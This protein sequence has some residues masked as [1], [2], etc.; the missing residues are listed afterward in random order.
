MVP[1]DAVSD[2][3]APEGTL[4]YT[5]LFQGGSEAAVAPVYASGMNKLPLLTVFAALVPCTPLTAQSRPA[6]LDTI[7]VSSR[8]RTADPA[9]V[10]SVISRDDIARS[11]ARNVAE[12]LSVQMGVDVYGRSAA[13]AD[14]S[15]RGS[16]ADQTL[17]LVDG[18]RMS[19]V[20]T[21]HYALDLAVPL[22]SIERIE[23]LHGSASTL[24]GADAVGGVINIITRRGAAASS[25]RAS[26]GTF[27]T[28]GGGA[29]T[30][31]HLGR[32]SLTTSADYDQSDGYRLGTDYRIGQGRIA[33]SAPSANGRL[34][35][36]LGIG[37]R[38]FG[39][40]TFYAPYNSTEATSTIT[41]DLRWAAAVGR[42]AV[43]TTIGTRRHTDRFTLI[44]ENPAVYENRHTNWQSSAEVV[45]RTSVG[46]AALA[47]G[48]EGLRASLRSARLGDRAETRT[49]AFGEVGIDAGRAATITLGL[50]G[51]HSSTF[52]DF[53]SPS[54]ALALPLTGRA[55]LHGSAGRGFR[56]PS[57]TDRYYVDPANQ[58]TADLVPER[59][60]SGEAGVRLHGRGTLALD[61]TG[62]ARNASNT[63]DWVKAANAP[64]GTKWVATNV[65]DA[66]YRGVE[67]TLTL[68]STSRWSGSLSGATLSF[69]G[70]SGAGLIGKYA[71]RPITRRATAQ[72]SYAP[73][74][75]IRAT[76]ALVGA[77]RATEDGYLTGNAR[78]EWRQSQFG[79]TL[80]ATNLAGAEW[81]DASGKIVAGR[82]L[83]VGVNWQGGR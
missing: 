29:I 75:S 57:W 71:L 30:T 60:W 8:A 78:L 61:V 55:T 6:V 10:V 15:L 70:S 1:L 13:Q 42:W 39:A 4:G 72:L 44:K 63:I 47:I 9:R 58:G 5:T 65:G 67:A 37:I 69:D 18:I 68:P 38:D 77:R 80:D 16:T 36:N 28:F 25:A 64:A 56:A 51:D 32:A 48:I 66:E 35:A 17:V 74:T 14:I 49:A 50:R 40:N 2:R 19:D 22:G 43:A 26:A 54:V 3:P 81:I 45:G 23:I 33:L 11:P 24:Y 12:L 21:S 82:A 76:A 59:F 83:Y 62:F 73:T 79:I 27:G 41:G 31:A 20:Q 52:G 7:V 46:G 53:V 34:D